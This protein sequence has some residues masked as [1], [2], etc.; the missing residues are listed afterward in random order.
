[1]QGRVSCWGVDRAI[2][3]A[4]ERKKLDRACPVEGHH[5]NAVV[6]LLDV[7]HLGRKR[8]VPSFESS[9]ERVRFLDKQLHILV[10][11]A[12]E[13]V[14]M[15]EQVADLDESGEADVERCS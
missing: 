5:K 3:R 7:L 9:F 1:M 8:V 12:V 11:E 2:R 13:L 14:H 10:L 15:T 4:H 6:V